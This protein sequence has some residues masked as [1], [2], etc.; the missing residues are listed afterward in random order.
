[1]EIHILI[2]NVYAHRQKVKGFEYHLHF[3]FTHHTTL[4]FE[5]VQCSGTIAAEFVQML[6]IYFLVGG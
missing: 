1:M 5:V 3:N 2:Y 4:S 6:F